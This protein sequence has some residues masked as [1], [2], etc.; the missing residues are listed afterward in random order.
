MP[1]KLILSWDIRQG[2]EQ[3]YFEFVIR[4]F[5]PGIQKLGYALSDAWATVFGQQPQIMVSLLGDDSHSVADLLDLPEWSE[6][7]IKL[8][9]LVDNYQQK[10]VRDKGGFQ[11]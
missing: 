5:I 7:Y 10:L 9:G 6:L 8:A 4:E 11:F 2:H 3:E 1:V